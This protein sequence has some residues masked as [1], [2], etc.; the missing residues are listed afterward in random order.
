MERRV[1]ITGIG[2]ITSNGHGK[3]EFSQ[4][5][6]QGKSGIRFRK[7][8]EEL[9]FGCQVGGWIDKEI[10]EEKAKKYFTEE[11]LLAMNEIMIL[12]SIAGI[13]AWKDAGFE[14]PDPKSDYV[15]W[16]AGCVIGL[17]LSGIDTIAEKVIPFI[18]SG[19]VRRLGSTMVEQIMMSSLSA[20]LSGLLA[21]GNN[22]F[23]NSSACN[24]GTEAILLSYERIKRGDAE[25]ML[26]GGAE[27]SSKYVWGAFD[28]MRVLSSK[29]ND[30]PERA[31][32]P[33]SASAAGFVPGSGAGIL[34]LESLEHAQKRGA[35]IYAEILG[36][37]LNCGGHRMGGSMTAP[38]PT[39]VQICIREAVKRACI[40]PEEIDAINGHLTATMADPIEVNNWS[41]ALGLPPEK[42]PYI[43]STKSLIGHTL[44]AAGS[45]ESVAVILQ[46][47]QGFLHPSINCEDIHE[48]IKPFEHRVV[49]ETIYKDVRIFAKASFG[50][51]DVN[52]CVIYKKWEG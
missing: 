18:D 15:N 30:Q 3:E 36:G 24:T 21:L 22:T 7:E 9:K 46:L 25:I 12:S 26:A 13:D 34:V 39:S 47:E 4:A 20:K 37:Y 17:G 11:E 48:K 50:F 16:D 51:G 33:M 23:S 29:Y 28:A 42:F 2:V 41:V 6:K 49:R 31:S 1:V 52:G 35:R 19:K 10:L 8:L 5:L 14:V 44:G 40:Q 45:I 27:S 43:Q 32:R 38:N